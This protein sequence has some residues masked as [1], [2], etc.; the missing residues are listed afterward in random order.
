V[1]VKSFIPV[2]I[3]VTLKPSSQRPQ[4]K[5]IFSE[6]GVSNLDKTQNFEFVIKMVFKFF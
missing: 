2:A 4:Q 3:V 5:L 1:T 6:D